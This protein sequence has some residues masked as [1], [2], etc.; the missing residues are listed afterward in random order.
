M[1]SRCHRLL[2]LRA[3]CACAVAAATPFAVAQS[4]PATLD[5]VVVTAT[6][7]AERSFDV[8]ASIDS[9]DGATIRDGEPAI[10]LSESLVRVP[11]VFAAN[12]NNYAQDLQISSRGFGAR[13]TF[14]VRGVRLYQ[15]FIPATMPDGQ[16]QTG[17]FSLLSA[18]RIE[19]LRGPFS[20]L[21][22]NASGGVIAVFTEDPAASPQFDF[23]AGAGSYATYNAGLKV[24]GT[25]GGVGYVL[26]GNHFDTDGYRAHSAATRDI[27]NAKLVFNLG[28]AT[29]VTV[30]G[31]SQ[32]QPD[33]QDPL[34]LTQAQ[35]ETNPRQADPATELFNTRKT[36]NQLQ[37]GVALEHTASA[38]TTLRVTGYGGR[39]QIGQYL[40]LSGAAPTSSGGVVNLDRDYGGLGARA[41]WKGEIGGGPLTLSAGVDADRMREKRQGFVNDNGSQGALR[42]DEDDTVDSADAYVEA[43][44]NVLPALSLTLGVRTSRVQY[45]STDHYVTGPNPDDSG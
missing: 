22:G 12:R 10:N 34:G 38:A 3:G 32:H 4:E 35:W 30:I 2:V 21:Y 39:R 40:A 16:G 6:R 7:R 14:G 44:W 42:R 36:V 24:S 5:P 28:E 18:Q 31:S 9:I 25:A 1:S 29:R 11:G 26:A 27:G 17:S 15:D 23:A 33:S 13:A 19:V 8:P 41:I 45:A 20:T 43:Q 37:G